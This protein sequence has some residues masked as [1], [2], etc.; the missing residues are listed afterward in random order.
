MGGGGRSIYTM[1]VERIKGVGPLRLLRPL[2]TV[3]R[4]SAPRIA[5]GARVPGCRGTAAADA[6]AL[7]G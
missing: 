7:H 4:S 3:L 1:V 2:C 5:N 6:F